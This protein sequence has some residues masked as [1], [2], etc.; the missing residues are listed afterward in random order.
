[1]T[2]SQ[3]TE[4]T[5]RP[6]ARTLR[7]AGKRRALLPPPAAS[8]PMVSPINPLGNEEPSATP[9]LET[10][11]SPE[12]AHLVS[13]P[14]LPESLAPMPV[15]AAGNEVASVAT[16]ME[17]FLLDPR[18]AIAAMY[19]EHPD[20]KMDR[21]TNYALPLAVR[22]SIERRSKKLG[23]PIKQVVAAMLLAALE[24]WEEPVEPWR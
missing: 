1:M 10:S 5:D 22:D 8:L 24:T 7:V 4:E 20:F 21:N 16:P 19:A 13:K 9:R 6:G 12:S 17:R 23:V 14:A 18:S 2:T 3:Q 11:A 15:T